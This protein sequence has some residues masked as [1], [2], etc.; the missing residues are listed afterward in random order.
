[1]GKTFLEQN[2]VFRVLGHALPIHNCTLAQWWT[3]GETG[4]T[5]IN[6]PILQ[7]WKL[8]CEKFWS[9][10]VPGSTKERTGQDKRKA[11]FF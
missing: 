10:Q 4:R 5:N 8:K 11:F 1:M 6:T 2:R 9:Q 3:G 7:Q